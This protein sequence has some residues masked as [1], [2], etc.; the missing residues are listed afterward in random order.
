M[1]YTIHLNEIHYSRRVLSAK[2]KPKKYIYT[3]KLQKRDQQGQKGW[4]VYFSGAVRIAYLNEC[5]MWK[6]IARSE[7][8]AIVHLVEFHALRLIVLWR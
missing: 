7:I 4:H 5:V 8:N 3:Q 6:I 2:I 1:K